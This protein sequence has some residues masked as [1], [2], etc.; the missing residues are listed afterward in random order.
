MSNVSR[1]CREQSSSL[2]VVRSYAG[3]R[4]GIKFNPPNQTLPIFPEG[5]KVTGDLFRMSRSEGREHPEQQS[6]LR[7][8]YRGDM[9]TCSQN[10]TSARL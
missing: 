8:P 9:C 1:G 3:I 2:L 4:G 10:G 5:C 6:I 7:D